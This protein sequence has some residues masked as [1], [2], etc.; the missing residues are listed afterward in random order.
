MVPVILDNYEENE[1]Q[2]IEA[3]STI[4]QIVDYVV[5]NDNDP[6]DEEIINF[7]LFANCELVTFEEASSDEN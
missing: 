1:R 5:G 6:S 7:D 3:S 4:N 2:A